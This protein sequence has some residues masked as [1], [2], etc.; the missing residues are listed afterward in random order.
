MWEALKLLVMKTDLREGTDGDMLCP[1]APVSLGT[2]LL[3]Q[4]EHGTKKEKEE[5]P[6]VLL[7]FEG[8]C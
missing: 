5:K 7:W 6:Y 4:T 8:N 1:A 3:S 2:Q